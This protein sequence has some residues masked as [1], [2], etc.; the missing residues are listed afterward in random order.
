M[1]VI[2]HVS[3][4]MEVWSMGVFIVAGIVS[5]FFGLM[6]LFFPEQ[7]RRLNEASKSLVTNIDSAMFTYRLGVGI[8]L[9]IASA[10]FFFVSYYIRARG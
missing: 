2:I 3:D 1:S 4:E 9:V 10:L 7:L 6:M 5:L 8:S